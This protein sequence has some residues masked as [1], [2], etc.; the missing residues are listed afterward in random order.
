MRLDPTRKTRNAFNANKEH[1]AKLQQVSVQTV[2]MAECLFQ[3]Q[4]KQRIALVSDLLHF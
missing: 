3:D 2:L 4:Q 1:G